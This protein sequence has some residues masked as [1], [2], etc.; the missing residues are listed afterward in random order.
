M[1]NTDY[2][3]RGRYLVTPEKEHFL[4]ELAEALFDKGDEEDLMDLKFIEL[5]IHNQEI[6][7]G[8]SRRLIRIEERIRGYGVEH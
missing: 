3:K 4:N 2:Y 7:D 1:S 8:A 5:L 6:N